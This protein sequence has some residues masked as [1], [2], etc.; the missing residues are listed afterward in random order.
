MGSGASVD[1]FSVSDQS[2]RAR[3]ARTRGGTR[4]GRGG[5]DR[6]AVGRSA[7]VHRGGGARAGWRGVREA[8]GARRGVA[9]DDAFGNERREGGDA[10][11]RSRRR[12]FNDR[13]RMRGTTTRRRAWAYRRGLARASRVTHRVA[14]SKVP[15]LFPRLVARAR[16]EVRLAVAR[17]DVLRPGVTRRVSHL[18]RGRRRGGARRR[19]GRG[20]IA[21]GSGPGAGA[22][23]RRPVRPESARAR[24]LARD[25]P[26][27]RARCAPARA[28]PPRRT[29]MR[30]RG[31]AGTKG[32][33][34][35]ARRR[36][37]FV[38][39]PRRRHRAT[40]ARPVAR[41][42][43]RRTGR[44]PLDR[45]SRR[46]SGFK[47]ARRAIDRDSRETDSRFGLPGF[48]RPR[49]ANRERANG[50]GGSVEQIFRTQREYLLMGS[51][52]ARRFYSFGICIPVPRI[53]SDRRYA[54][55]KPHQIT[56]EMIS[57]TPPRRWCV[58]CAE[59]YYAR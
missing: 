51:R 49:R 37:R 59:L 36:G 12:F 14:R 19:A 42:A 9:R 5:I 3:S 34:I 47:N 58:W 38:F 18:R 35:F 25:V 11:V 40:R 48:D 1:R 13:G 26:R 44:D 24:L 22:T 54:S 29:T 8:R 4:K 33:K 21:G 20:H 2:R 17:G 52:R 56:P 7:R 6:G 27:A 28:P 31:Q 16:R 43:N 10:G 57:F 55:F 53:P 32:K 45:S 30:C 39:S 15:P 41:V 46:V 23:A 50:R